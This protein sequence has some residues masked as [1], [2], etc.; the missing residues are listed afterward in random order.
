MNIV[1]TGFGS[2]IICYAFF[3]LTKTFAPALATGKLKQMI[4][5]WGEKKA[6]WIYR[7]GYFVIPCLFGIL[8]VLAGIRGESLS[9]FLN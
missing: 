8:V 9:Q 5:F 4:E 6:L 2:L 7:I 1:T 3:L